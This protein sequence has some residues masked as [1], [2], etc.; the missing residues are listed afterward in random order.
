M[1][2]QQLYTLLT[3]QCEF[4]CCNTVH[5]H[6]G[7]KQQSC[8]WFF[9]CSALLRYPC[10]VTSSD[11]PLAELK[12]RLKRYPTLISLLCNS[13]PPEFFFLNVQPC[14]LQIQPTLPQITLRTL[15]TLYKDAPVAT[16]GFLFSQY[17]KFNTIKLVQI[18]PVYPFY[19]ATNVHINKTLTQRHNSYPLHMAN[20]TFKV[21]FDVTINYIAKE[22]RTN[23]YIYI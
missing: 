20:H 3:D 10:D 23:T 12:S 15:I 11:Y 16:E 2:Y 18:V 8:C 1:S 7:K 14:S 6:L 17:V 5:D 22:G 9:Q 21:F 19:C 4:F 13:T